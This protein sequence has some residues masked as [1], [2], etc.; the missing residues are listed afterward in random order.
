MNQTWGRF[1]S[2]TT[3]FLHYAERMSASAAGAA[4]ETAWDPV[5]NPIFRGLRLKSQSSAETTATA[6]AA[7]TIA[8]TAAAAGLDT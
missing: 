8:A 2:P 6:A 3:C 4:R 7:T 1:L 5:A